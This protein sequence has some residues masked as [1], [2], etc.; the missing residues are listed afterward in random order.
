MACKVWLRS[1]LDRIWKLVC[2]LFWISCRLISLRCTWPTLL[3]LSLP[4]VNKH[5]IVEHDNSRCAKLASWLDNSLQWPPTECHV[6]KYWQFHSAPVVKGKQTMVFCQMS[7]QFLIC[8]IITFIL[9]LVIARAFHHCTNEGYMFFIF[10]PLIGN[11]APQKGNVNWYA[12]MFSNR[13]VSCRHK[14]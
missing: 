10:P 6:L 14:E 2:L 12:I 13:Q 5:V 11:A 9:L 8:Y 1:F 3:S 7:K 4:D